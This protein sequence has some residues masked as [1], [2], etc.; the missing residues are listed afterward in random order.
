M[1]SEP[2]LS[3]LI[4]AAIESRLLD[5][6]TAI[7]GTIVS[8]DAAT[9][10]C[11]VQPIV[12]QAS[13]KLETALTLRQL[14]QIQNVPVIFQR[15]GGYAMTFPLIAG[16]SVVLLFNEASF[17]QWRSTGI[18]SE[19]GDV[20]RFALSYPVAL[21]GLAPSARALQSASATDMVLGSDL[22][23]TKFTLNPAE[24]LAGTKHIALQEA[25]DAYL[26]ALETLLQSN[27]WLPA[28]PSPASPWVAAFT[29][30]QSAAAALRAAIP[31]T[32]PNL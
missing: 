18:V 12:K 13:K 21:P 22:L 24:I 27:V 23:A 28:P 16:D 17:A 26:S 5:V 8:Y 11:T 15:G 7:I 10:T 6:H 30:F 9:Q 31:S 1:A 19:P 4:S 14:P 3:E 29:T 25:L 32:L 20:K 2:S